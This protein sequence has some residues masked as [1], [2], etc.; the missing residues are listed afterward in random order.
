MVTSIVGLMSLLLQ[1]E[2]EKASYCH[3]YK[4]VWCLTHIDLDWSD[5]PPLPL[6]ADHCV[7]K[8]NT[9]MV[10]EP[11]LELRVEPTPQNSSKRNAVS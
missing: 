8:Y 9:L 3:Q 6:Q 10:A 7:G 2:K 11:L 1:E 4:V 5:V